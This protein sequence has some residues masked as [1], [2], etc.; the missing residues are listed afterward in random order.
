MPVT[1]AV[2]VMPVIPG[3]TGPEVTLVPAAVRATLALKATTVTPEITGMGG[4]EAHAVMLATPA[5]LATP[6]VAEAAAEAAEAV[7]VLLSVTPAVQAQ[8]IQAMRDRGALALPILPSPELRVTRVTRGRQ[9]IMGAPERGQTQVP[10]VTPEM[11]ARTVMLV[12]QAQ[13]V[14]VER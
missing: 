5:M 2:Q 6:G 10:Q 12:A 7:Q 1:P 3:I 11:L 8:A 4:L 14:T 9:A 13:Q